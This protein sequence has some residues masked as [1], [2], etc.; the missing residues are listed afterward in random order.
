MTESGTASASQTSNDH[1]F[2]GTPDR[3]RRLTAYAEAT[4]SV[5][6][7][8]SEWL[9]G[10]AWQHDE[11]RARDASALDYTFDVP[12]VIARHTWTPVRWFATQ[13]SARCDA[14][15]VYGFSCSPRVSALW[16]PVGSWHTRLSLGIANFAPTPLTDES[17]AIGLGRIDAAAVTAEHARSASL[18]V[19]GSPLGVELNLTLAYSRIENPVLGVPVVVGG[20]SK[21]RYVNAPGPAETKAIEF[22]AS[23]SWG[24]WHATA[25]YGYL[26]GISFDPADSVTK[27]ATLVPRH[28]IGG[29][30][31]YE[32][33]TGGL[34]TIDAFY[35][36]EQPLA[37]DPYRSKSVPY[38]LV[39]IL[40]VQPIRG[41][42]ELWL[43]GENLLNVKQ[44]QYD[45]LLLPA[46]DALG[47]RTTQVWGPLEGRVVNLGLRFKW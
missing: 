22:F 42:L 39:C 33:A 44:T 9:V 5:Q 23:R 13:T 30:I 4:W 2:G 24:P 8:A 19:G 45:P 16:K 46:P 26:D 6:R 10:A 41:G 29:G 14:H 40:W 15:N 21:L 35:T 34:V 43:N 37:A 47:R 12:A 32:P 18:D 25:I 11:L 38:T 31:G 17:D 28:A 27:A 3:Q 20:V 1:G 7:G 36:G